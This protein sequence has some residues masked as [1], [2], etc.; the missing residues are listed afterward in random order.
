MEKRELTDRGKLTVGFGVPIV[1]LSAAAVTICAYGLKKTSGQ[2]NQES[3][4]ELSNRSGASQL[5]PA[6]VQE[7]PV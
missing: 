6:T 2:G 4:I 7:P 1:V 3:S 5:P